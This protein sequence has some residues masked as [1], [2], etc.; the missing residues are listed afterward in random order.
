MSMSSEKLQLQGPFSSACLFLVRHCNAD[1]S[2]YVKLSEGGTVV[3]ADCFD[4]G[5]NP[6]LHNFLS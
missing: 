2:Q 3:V 5:I 6:P 4:I 1:E